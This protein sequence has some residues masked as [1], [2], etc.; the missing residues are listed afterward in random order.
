MSATIAVL[1][2]Q[3]SWNWAH[4]SLVGRQT[5]GY[6]GLHAMQGTGQLDPANARHGPA[7]GTLLTYELADTDATLCGNLGVPMALEY[8]SSPRTS[9]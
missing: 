5:V 2:I 4:H 3:E 9:R 7:T 1:Q 6:R 8:S